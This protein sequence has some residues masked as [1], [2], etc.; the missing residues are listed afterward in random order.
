[1]SRNLDTAL[2]RAFVA[3]ADTAGMTAAAAVLNLTQAAVS[4]QIKRLEESFGCEL[5]TRERKGLRLT[6]AGERLYG[7]AKRLLALNDEIWAD[8]TTPLFDGKVRLG[9]PHD[10][11]SVYLPQVLKDFAHSYP[12]VE[13]T[14]DCATSPELLERLKEGVIDLT[15]TTE[16]GCGPDG[17]SLATERL[18]WAGAPGGEAYARRPLPLSVGCKVCAFRPPVLEALR[19]AEIPWRPVSDI[20]NLEAQCATA[21]ADLAVLALLAPTVPGT[22]AILPP[23]SGLPSLPAFSI[24]LYLPRGRTSAV[25]EELARHIRMSFHGGRRLA[26]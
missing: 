22:L 8:M 18:V 10:L 19:A 5:F 23:S 2:L 26:A 1:M 7:R 3:V 16:L 20:T 9:I 25:A 13:V 14:L 15:L 4:Q 21:Q 6:P 24:N 11:V 12:N 17:E